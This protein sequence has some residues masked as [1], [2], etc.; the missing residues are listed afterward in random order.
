MARR[1]KT[2]ETTTTN[3]GADHVATASA[4]TENTPEKGQATQSKTAQA[5]SPKQKKATTAAAKNSA[6]KKTDEP[7]SVE[8][9]FVKAIPG[10]KSFRRAG[11][12]FNEQGFGIALDALDD[13]QLKALEEESNLV[14]EPCTFEAG[15]EY[16]G[17]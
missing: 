9:V 12:G 14:V 10:L 2:Q 1:N 13:G 6:A 4:A 15:D 7:P 3:G 16:V 8:G 11:Y 5:G 17:K